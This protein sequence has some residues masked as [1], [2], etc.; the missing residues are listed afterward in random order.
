MVTGMKLRLK[1]IGIDTHRES[2]A[3]LAHDDLTSR[4]LGLHPMDRVEIAANSRR[5]VAV[6]NVVEGNV[7][8]VGAIGL[9]NEAFDKLG[10]M[11]N[12]LVDVGPAEAPESLDLLHE[13]LAG[14]QLQSHDFERIVDDIVQGRYSKVELTAF[15]VSATI[16][17]LNNDETMWLTEAM[18]KTG[19]R[20]KFDSSIVADKHSIGGVPGNRTTPIITSIAAAAGLLIPKTSSRSVTSPAGT[21]DTV[22]ALM[23]VE[24]KADQIYEVVKEENGCL[25]WG[26]SVNLAPADDMIIQIEHSLSI[27]AQSM[28]ISSIL[29]KKKAAGATHVIL[30]IPVGHGTKAETGVKGESLKRRFL[31]LGVRLGLNVRVLLTDGSQPIGNGIGP[32]LEAGDVIKVLS[33]DSEAPMDLR[34]KS[35]YL[36]GELL[37]LCGQS[38]QGGGRVMAEQI[39]V[40][41]RALEKF[42]RIRT[43]QGRHEIPPLGS[44]TKDVLAEKNG[45]VKAVDNRIVSR[46]AQ[47]AGAPRN[48]GAGVYLARHVN[49][50]V[51]KGELLM[52]LFAESDEALA[53][54]ARYWLE[55]SRTAIIIA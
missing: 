52:R 45:Q 11:D 26:G 20:L 28:M 32:A 8:P 51:K 25:A 29:A 46:V 30:D 13:K 1:R 10:V 47:L 23:N 3:F 5:L 19:D 22:E 53:F 2:I 6:L 54:A 42:E 36:A 49:D 7:V 21:A 17:G 43:L 48:P 44:H 50:V 40:S 15:V 39:L 24:L 34:E 18:I 35:L 27:D 16:N 37:E 31:D 55:N 4:A 14:H 9:S 38:V 41:G 33:N 12:S